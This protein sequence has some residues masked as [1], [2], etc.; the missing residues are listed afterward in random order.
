MV[1]CYGAVFDLNNDGVVL[2]PALGVGLPPADR[3]PRAGAAPLSG[4]ILAAAGAEAGRTRADRVPG[5]E[6][7]SGDPTADLPYRVARAPR[8]RQAHPQMALPQ[9]R[10]G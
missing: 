10:G 9:L 6:P 8:L 2:A 1:I 5:Q 7:T 4:R 3:G